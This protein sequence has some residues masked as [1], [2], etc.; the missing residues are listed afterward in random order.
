[1]PAVI[2]PVGKFIVYDCPALCAGPCNIIPWLLASQLSWIAPGF[3]AP[4]ISTLPVPFGPTF[5]SILESPPVA[6]ID[7]ALPVAALVI[8]NWF[9]ADDVVWNTIC[10]F[11]FS[12]LIPC[13]SSKAMLCEL[14]S[15]SPPSCGVVSSTI[16]E[17]PKAIV[18][19]LGLV[20]SL[21]VA[22]TIASPL[23]VA[24]KVNESPE[25]DAYLN[26]TVYAPEV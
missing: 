8:S 20:E 24:E 13:A 11:P 5:K 4:N 16:F 14:V 18:S 22:N 7:G 6:W 25:P 17:I 19:I 23:S 9:T 26:C 12:S 21:A 1:M 2:F 3:V 10:S 15:K